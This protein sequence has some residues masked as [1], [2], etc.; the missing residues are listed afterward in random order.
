MNMVNSLEEVKGLIENNQMMLLY[1]SSSSCSVCSAV[2]PKIKDILKDYPKIKSAQIDVEKSL[3]ISAA[4]NIFTI[5]AILIYIEG[6]EII[7]EARN[8]S[9]QDLSSKIERYYNMLFE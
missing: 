7:R 2:K 4:Y 1:F 3:D 6:K 8:I 5:P 9:I